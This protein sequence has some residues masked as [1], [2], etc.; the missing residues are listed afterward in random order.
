MIPHLLLMHGNGGSRTRFLPA[1]KEI[2]SRFPN[3]PLVIPQL[4]GFDGRWLP[5][6]NKYWDVFLNDLYESVS[7]LLEVPWI[8]YGHGIG[9]SLLMELASRNFVF[10]NGKVMPVK[11]VILHS[12]V[13]PALE[14]RVFPN[15]MKPKWV[16]KVAQQLITWPYLRSFWEKRLFQHP[17]AL[18]LDLRQQFFEDYAHCTAF[19]VF[20]DLITAEWYRRVRSVC[21]DYPFYFLWGNKERVLNV[22]LLQYLQADFPYSRFEV[23]TGW[24]H[25]PMMENPEEFVATL[26]PIAREKC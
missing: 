24:D 21:R 2:E 10:P 25:F 16:R 1:L 14:R 13:G 23:K 26:I 12:V 5:D 11:G 6:S 8:L 15:V 18:S 17:E 19:P 22:K 9:G 4:S 3:Q 7:D 20:F